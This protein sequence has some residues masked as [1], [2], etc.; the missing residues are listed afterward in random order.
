MTDTTWKAAERKHAKA[1]GTE[2]IPVSGRQRDKH[3]ADFEDGLVIYQVKH[4]YHQPTYLLEWLRGICTTA[5]LHNKLGAVIW[6]KKGGRI[7]DSLVIVRFED[8]V[9][10]HGQPSTG[11]ENGD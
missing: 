7:K 6:Q 11:R 8:W 9:Q 2:R 4:G 10:M 1:L 3:G 5:F